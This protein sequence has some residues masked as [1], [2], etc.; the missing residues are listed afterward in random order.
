V[1]THTYAEWEHEFA[2]KLKLAGLE[3][4]KANDV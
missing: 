4:D 2:D 1:P 3:P